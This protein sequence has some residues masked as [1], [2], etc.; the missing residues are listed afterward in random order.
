M[1][2]VPPDFFERMPDEVRELW[3]DPVAEFMGWPF[4]SLD[5]P[6]DDRWRK[7]F[8]SNSPK[9]INQYRWSLEIFNP[10]TQ[11]VRAR[12]NYVLE[13]LILHFIKGHSLK[14][15]PAAD[16]KQKFLACVDF[17]RIHRT[18]PRYLVLQEVKGGMCI[19]DGFHRLSALRFLWQVEGLEV[20]LNLPAWVARS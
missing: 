5:S 4:K 13:E 20:N 6:P 14:I 9:V 16:T 3:L 18:I 12:D 8:G 17:I 10:V 15:E 2:S 7:H 11:P 1:K 19:L